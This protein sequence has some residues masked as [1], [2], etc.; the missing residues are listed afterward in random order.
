MSSIPK[1]VILTAF[2]TVHRPQGCP[3][4]SL[5]H[6]TCLG[7]HYE[8]NVPVIFFSFEHKLNINSLCQRYLNYYSLIASNSQVSIILNLEH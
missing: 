3:Y 2:N 5:R 7:L 1:S 4:C 6:S 8:I